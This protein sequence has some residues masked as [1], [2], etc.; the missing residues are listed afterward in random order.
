MR[1]P[2]FPLQQPVAGARVP[3]LDEV[4]SLAGKGNG[5]GFNIET[6]IFPAE[7]AL[8]PPPEEFARM[9]ADAVRRHRLEER[10]IVQSFDFRTLQA[11][12]KIA[13]E[14]KLAALYGKGERS[15]VDVAREAGAQI[16]SPEFHLV[17]P[18]QVEEAH[19]AG[20]QVVPWTAN[21]VGGLGPADRCRGWTPS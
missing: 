20:L 4:L 17:T 15:F 5:F 6:K 3:T 13:P 1:N 7:P 10:V 8:T 12:K 11:L 9:V 18:A 14:L 19:R 16:V 2:G 21:S